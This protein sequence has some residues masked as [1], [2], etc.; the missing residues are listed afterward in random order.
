[1][2]NKYQPNRRDKIR[3]HFHEHPYY[4]LSKTVFDVF[5]ELCPTMVM[6][7]EQLFEDASLTLDRLLQTGDVKTEQCQSLWTDKYGLYREQDNT[8]CST[9]DTQTEVAMLFYMIM[10]GV[11]VVNHSH[12]RG[13]LQRTLHDCICKYYGRDKCLHAEKMLSNS[14]NQHTTEMLAWM[15]EYLVGGESLTQEIHDLLSPPKK[16][17]AK[18]SRKKKEI[19]YYT[20]PYNCQ[21]EATRVNRV[22]I[23]MRKMQEWKWIKEPRVADDFDHFFDGDPRNCNL[24]WIGKPQA[25][26][27]EL[28]KQLLEQ[29]YMNKKTGV[30][31]RSIVM[32]QFGLRPSGNKERIDAQNWERIK[33]IVYILDYHK[34]L[35]L[36]KKGINEGYDISDLALQAVFAKDL[37]I[38]KDLNP[39]YE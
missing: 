12:Y 2:A 6:T 14:A 16:P 17:G 4:K 25:I 37:H 36:P 3:I 39:T 15:D 8:S 20:L 10:L 7:P 30:S 34:S 5:Q 32:S 1:M 38:T 13:R 35:P 23:V 28:I 11:Q 33:M 24:E 27:T 21:D 22:N 18:E 29:P 19:V 31:A 9:T 26:L